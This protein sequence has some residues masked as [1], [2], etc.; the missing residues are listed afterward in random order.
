MINRDYLSIENT[1]SLKG[2]TAILV[3]IHHLFQYSGLLRFPI[4]ST[5]LQELGYWSVALFFFLS[6]YGLME[7]YKKKR[8][9]YMEKFPRKRILSLYC[10]CLFFV[11]L[12]FIYNICSGNTIPLDRLI[13]S[14]IC[15]HK[16]IQN[17][18]YL[19]VI[20][21][22]YIIFYFVFRTKSNDKTKIILYSAVTLLYSICLMMQMGLTWYQGIF[23]MVLGMLWSYKK[24][25]IDVLLNN[26][27][28][29]FCTILFLILSFLIL[30]LVSKIVRGRVGNLLTILISM[31]F[32]CAIIMFT[33]KIKITNKVTYKLGL[34][35]LEIYLLQGMFL[36]GFQGGIMN[37]ENP[38][39]YVVAVT[40]ATLLSSIIMHPIIKFLM[41]L[42]GGIK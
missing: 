8:T 9:E 18:W 17:G 15:V 16:L 32:V 39:V 34:I 1:I 27:K 24:E 2:I 36:T 35:S 28:K 11:F 23:S 5:I 33:K 4:V 22:L 6:G 25:N 38:I 29:Y 31:T 41:K 30:L 10:V 26:K 20:L 21:T 37:I 13:T 12:Y 40:A 42:A 14:F 19:S 7:S 3:L